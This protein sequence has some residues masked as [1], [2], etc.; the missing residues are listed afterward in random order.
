MQ[1]NTRCINHLG[2]FRNIG[3]KL[4]EKDIEEIANK[5]TFGS[6]LLYVREFHLI[7]LTFLPL[8]ELSM[9]DFVGRYDIR[10]AQLKEL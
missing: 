4:K 5:K 1:V 10:C 6:I 3:I 9:P 8:K 7:V 2:L